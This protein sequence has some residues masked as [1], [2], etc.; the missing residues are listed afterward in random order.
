[1][2]PADA[3][4]GIAPSGGSEHTVNLDDLQNMQRG[5]RPGSGIAFGLAARKS[6]EGPYGP[7]NISASSRRRVAFGDTEFGLR[8]V[9]SKPFGLSSSLF[10]GLRTGRLDSRA[11]K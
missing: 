1:M 6:R 5:L 2:P 11:C 4:G 3:G 10:P 9:P 7:R 8:A